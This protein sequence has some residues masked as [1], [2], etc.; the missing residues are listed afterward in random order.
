VDHCE[1]AFQPKLRSRVGLAKILRQPPEAQTMFDRAQQEARD[2]ERQAWI[3]KHTEKLAR[4]WCGAG[5]CLPQ[6][7]R[8]FYTL[9]KPAK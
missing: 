1:P 5:F 3:D 9:L 8:L 7:L 6:P 4:N 2:A